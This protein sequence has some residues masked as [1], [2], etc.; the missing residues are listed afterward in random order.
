MS[1][2]KRF[3]RAKSKINGIFDDLLSYSNDVAKFLEAYEGA[4]DLNVS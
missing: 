2:L 4:D 1:P 3:G